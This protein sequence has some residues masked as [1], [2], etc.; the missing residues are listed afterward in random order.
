[1]V[2]SVINIWIY[3]G[4]VSESV[5]AKLFETFNAGKRNLFL[6]LSRINLPEIYSIIIDC[7]FGCPVRILQLFV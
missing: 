5:V 1:M 4:W 6:E 3:M 2:N 7:G